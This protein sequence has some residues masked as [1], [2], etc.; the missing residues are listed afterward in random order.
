MM[1]ALSAVGSF[2]VLALTIVIAQLNNGHGGTGLQ[3]QGRPAWSQADRS[4]VVQ[5][6][7]A[8]NAEVAEGHVAQMRGASPTVRALGARMV[9]DHSLAG[10]QLTAIARR[11]GLPMTTSL[12]AGGSMELQ[13]LRTLSGRAFDDAY[14]SGN[15]PDHHKAI[16][17]LQGEAANGRDSALR[18][19]A[20][21]T[22]PTLR[23]HLSLFESAWHQR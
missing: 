3:V 21:E 19:W 9:H 16:A 18:V 17:L 5:A 23:V 14:V 2:L 13:H 20:R 22:L 11:E 7:E 12:G 15:V 1:N 10:Y 4:F 8:G 6:E